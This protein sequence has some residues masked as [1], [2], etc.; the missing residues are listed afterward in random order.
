MTYSLFMTTNE[1]LDA[2]VKGLEIN[3]NDDILAVCGSGDQAF[4]MLEYAGSV[5]A[6]DMDR[7][8][9]EYATGRM[10]ALKNGDFKKF[11]PMAEKYFL[12]QGRV[13]VIA[14]KLEMLEIRMG[15]LQHCIAPGV[16]SKAY[17]S[18]IMGYSESL[19]NEKECRA[20]M[21]MLAE[22]L[23]APC[24]VYA[25]NGSSWF[26]PGRSHI[27]QEDGWLTNEAKKHESN[28]KPIVY[29]RKA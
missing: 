19:C 4:A 8:Q 3:G 15:E 23:R 16:F 12:E 22:R 9:V 10:N 7:E 20:L 28:W 26:H 5:V 14:G 25:S 17:I 11:N 6:V 29:R 21:Q 24:I 27:L 2:I 13:G 1:S 18:N